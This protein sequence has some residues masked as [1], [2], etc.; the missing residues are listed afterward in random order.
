LLTG[1]R[2]IVD[3]HIRHFDAEPVCVLK[4]DV[5]L[6]DVR[7]IPTQAGLGCLECEG[8]NIAVE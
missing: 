1:K 7:A 3:F 5:V 4:L 2:V 6:F 8:S